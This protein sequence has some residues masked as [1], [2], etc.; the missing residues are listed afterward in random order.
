[1][2]RRFAHIALPVFFAVCIGSLAGVSSTQAQAVQRLVNFQ[3]PSRAVAMDILPYLDDPKQP[4]VALFTVARYKP[5]VIALPANHIG[6][7]A[8]GFAHR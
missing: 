7:N 4:R 3:Q 2:M 1:M 5:N 8:L 6:A